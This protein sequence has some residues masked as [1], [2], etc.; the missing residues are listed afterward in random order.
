MKRLL[1]VLAAALVISSQA[2]AASDGLW[3]S[4]AIT[5]TTDWTTIANYTYGTEVKVKTNGTIS[6]LV[7]WKS[8][9]DTTTSRNLILWDM[10]GDNLAECTTSSEPTGTAQWVGCAL[11]TPYAVAGNSSFSATWVTYM[12]SVDYPT[13]SIVP[14]VAGACQ[15]AGGS[16]GATDPNNANL[17]CESTS[18]SY[19]GGLSTFPNT[20][21]TDTTFADVVFT[22]CP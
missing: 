6:Q 20:N 12:V 9:A 3:H 4:N 13:G 18:Q 8:A 7:F 2:F 11:A 1:F 14:Y 10:S 5:G 16:V 19:Y 15:Q 21:N 17:I 22:P